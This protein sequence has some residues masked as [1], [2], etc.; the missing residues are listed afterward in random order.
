MLIPMC[1][2]HHLEIQFL[3]QWH[4]S[5]APSE[6]TYEIIHNNSYL[7]VNS[8]AQHF[9][10][11]DKYIIY[12]TIFTVAAK[13]TWESKRKKTYVACSDIGL[14]MTYLF[15][16][17]RSLSKNSIQ[18]LHGGY[19]PLIWFLNIERIQLYQTVNQKTN[20]LYVSVIHK[21]GTGKVC[22]VGFS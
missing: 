6:V 20:M 2:F 22:I 14:V 4:F 5:S 3:L 8:Q 17:F 11:N 16:G 12:L 7:A 18:L 19:C 15:L 13:P 21:L 10:E 1:A 9:S